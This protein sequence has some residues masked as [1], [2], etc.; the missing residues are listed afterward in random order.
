MNDL[1]K[2]TEAPLAV[3]ETSPMARQLMTVQDL[4]SQVQLV[5][6]VMKE[7]M[8]EGQHF[9]V[10]PGTD[11]PTLYKPGAEKLAVV[12]RLAP[13]FRIERFDLGDGHREER[14]TCTLSHISTG[15]VWGEGVGTCSTM[16]KKYRWR[17]KDR[18]CPTCGEA[19]IL[20]SKKGGEGWFC[21]RKKGGCGAT[22]DVGDPSVERQETGRQ[23]NPDIAD[24]WNTVLKMAK[25]RAQV[26]ATIS[27][28]GASDIFAQDLEDL[29]DVPT[30]REAP[31]VDPRDRPPL[32]DS[33]RASPDVSV[34]APAPAG[35]PGELRIAAVRSSDSLNG[36]TRFSIKLNDGRNLH[37]FSTTI[38]D[39]ARIY[40]QKGA[41]VLVEVSE[42][43][44]GSAVESLEPS[45]APAKSKDDINW[46]D[47]KQA[48]IWLA[49][50]MN[51]R[52][53]NTD[54]Q[55]E[56]AASAPAILA[57]VETMEEMGATVLGD[58]FSEILAGKWDD[59]GTK[60]SAEAVKAS[61]VA[62]V[63]D[64]EFTTND[65]DIPF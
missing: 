5:Q 63:T 37:T 13:G 14:V 60:R 27:V 12:F 44:Y 16:E 41:T 18:A 24:T 59:G 39:R 61:P 55:R 6:Q 30:P 53:I 47:L 40:E 51:V 45:S 64:E 28:T 17:Q 8:Q 29:P 21:W 32:E 46:G 57:E 10:I 26:D 23:E 38:G 2:H 52:G 62:A 36:S 56:I 9:G 20:R 34:A 48:K 1:A 33:R 22:F 58:L 11:K 35:E 42:D 15:E 54:K 65:A 4:T 31:Q 7:V 50:A 25:K 3:I 43:E 19:A 49:T